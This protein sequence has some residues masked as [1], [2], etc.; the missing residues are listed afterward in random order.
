MKERGEV[1]WFNNS[2]GFGE[3]LGANGEKY[4]AHYN[5]I[6]SKSKFKVLTTGQRVTFV[7]RPKALPKFSSY[8]ELEKAAGEIEAA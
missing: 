1:L 8:R 7:A 2:K 6:V 3:I 4:F 5:E